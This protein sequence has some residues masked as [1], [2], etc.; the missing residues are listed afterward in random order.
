MKEK[1]V[2]TVCGA[3]TAS[4]YEFEGAHYCPQC[5]ERHLIEC[6]CCGQT[7]LRADSIRVRTG[8]RYDRH[9]NYCSKCAAQ[10]TYTCDHC[11]TIC[12]MDYPSYEVSD[13]II[14]Q[15]CIDT[16][17]YYCNSCERYVYY[18]NYSSEEECCH[19]CS[20]RSEYVS[21]Y[22][23][24]SDS[25]SEIGTAKKSWKGKWRGLGIELEIDRRNNPGQNEM[26]LANALLGIASRNIYFERDGS[27]EYG[28]EII[29][30]PHT[31]EEFYKV[32]WA[33]ILHLCK[34]HGYLSHDAKT[35]GLHIHVSRES[36]GSNDK[37]QATAL[38]KIMYFYGKFWNDIL[39]LSRR[40]E[41]QANQWAKNYCIKDKNEARKQLKKDMGRYCA[42]NTMNDSTIEFRLARGTLNL[43]TFLSWIDFTLTLVRNSKKIKWS[44]I[45]NIKL[46]LNGMKPQ[47]THHLQQKEIFGEVA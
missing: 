10:H 12:D 13:D 14:C 28:F 17:Y 4:L 5:Q 42:I 47:T 11:E 20:Y 27:L 9:Q 32:N 38:S 39:K 8:G 22:H 26:R 19:S 31:V 21:G 41:S 45:D 30:Q 35:C 34:Q 25:W 6:G 29:S 33:Q 3:E 37:K 43:D 16:D 24:N 36:F 15:H 40:T 7:I 1:M 46:W 23:A 44:E 2:C 18:E